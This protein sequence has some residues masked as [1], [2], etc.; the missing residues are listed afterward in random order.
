MKRERSNLELANL[1]TKEIS[2][3]DSFIYALDVDLSDWFRETKNVKGIIAKTVETK[4]T[5]KI[6]GRRF[7]GIG[8]LEH[9]IE[10][11]ISTIAALVIQA[12]NIRKSKQQEFKSL[13]T[14][15]EA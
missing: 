15:H 8:A 1:L 14:I 3:L 7:F 4:T 10:V 11:P 5:Y 13:F 2:Q 9:T 6:F 12:K